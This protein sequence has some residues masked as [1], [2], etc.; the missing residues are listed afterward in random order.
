[1]RQIANFGL[2]LKIYR[3]TVAGQSRDIRESVSQLSCECN[4]FSFKFVQQSRDIRASVA[5]RM[6]LSFIFSPDSR[7]VFASLSRDHRATLAQHSYEC[8]EKSSHCKFFKISQQQVH[9]TRTNGA[10]PSHDCRVTVLRNILE[11]KFA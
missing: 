8:C 6:L 9:D 1:M 3:A 10:R 2:I 5:R 4:L 7:E 11:K